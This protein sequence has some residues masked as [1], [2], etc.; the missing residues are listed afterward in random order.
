MPCGTKAPPAPAWAP[1]DP[2]ATAPGAVKSKAGLLRRKRLAKAEP[3]RELGVGAGCGGGDEGEESPLA[4]RVADASGVALGS[5]PSALRSRLV[6]MPAF[7]T[8]D[9]G[10]EL[11]SVVASTAA[12][13]PAA[14]RLPRGVLR[15]CSN[16][17]RDRLA[18]V[19]AS[20]TPSFAGGNGGTWASTGVAGRTPAASPVTGVAAGSAV[21]AVAIP[22]AWMW[23]CVSLRRLAFTLAS[24]CSSRG[25]S[26]GSS[27]G[28][29]GEKHRHLGRSA[30]SGCTAR[31]PSRAFHVGILLSNGGGHGS[32]QG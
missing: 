31:Y 13:T 17:E 1:A 12:S 4:A 15:A 30:R 14:A 9:G 21:G 7:S 3:R 10:V 16:H 18:R 8:S 24:V 22:V 29:R 28:E 11:P 5:P 32:D 2:A 19:P 25:R 26:G 20:V 6:P 27:K 23:R